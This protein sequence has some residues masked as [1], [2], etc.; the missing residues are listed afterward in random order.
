MKKTKLASQG[1][2]IMAE[3][4]RIRAKAKGKKWQTCVKEAAKK[5]K[6]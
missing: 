2:R 3:A 4:K 5:L 1:K 6:K